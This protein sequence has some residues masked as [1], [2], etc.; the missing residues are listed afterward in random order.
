MFIVLMAFLAILLVAGI[1]LSIVFSK[2]KFRIYFIAVNAFVLALWLGIYL[3]YYNDGVNEFEEEAEYVITKGDVFAGIRYAG[4]I[5]GYV[6]IEF[7][8]LS[9]EDPYV[10]PA[11]VV[12]VSNFCKV[13]KS[14]KIYSEHEKSILSG[15]ENARVELSDGTYGYLSETIRKI[16]PD[17]ADLVLYSGVFGFFILLIHSVIC[18]IIV[19]SRRNKK[20]NKI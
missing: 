19:L 16:K 15:G 8:G 12:E 20:K 7:T 2:G 5:D 13:Y 10:V 4:E 18:A 6:K 11:D 1:V 3:V 14:I 17:Y 9:D